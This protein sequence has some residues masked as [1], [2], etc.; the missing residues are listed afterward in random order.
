MSYLITTVSM[1]EIQSPLVWQVLCQ[2]EAV[3]PLVAN[4]LI[5]SKTKGL[6]FMESLN[7]LVLFLLQIEHLNCHKLPPY[8]LVSWKGRCSLPSGR[9][10]DRI[11]LLFS[12]G[13]LLSETD[14][15]PVGGGFPG[16]ILLTSAA[17]GAG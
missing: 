1:G 10:Q 5:S 11:P 3:A 7:I 4:S 8:F 16:L 6:R 2:T 14:T 17:C 13:T 12:T 9:A 15:C